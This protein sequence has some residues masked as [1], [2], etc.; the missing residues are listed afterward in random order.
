MNFSAAKTAICLRLVCLFLESLCSG[1]RRHIIGG[2]GQFL[3]G[4]R[5]VSRGECPRVALREPGLAEVRAEEIRELQLRATPCATP[6]AGRPPPPAQMLVSAECDSQREPTPPACV[7]DLR[8]VLVWFALLRRRRRWL[9]GWLVGSGGMPAP[10]AAAADTWQA[11]KR[12]SAMSSSWCWLQERSTRKCLSKRASFLRE[13][14]QAE[15]VR[16]ETRHD[17]RQPAKRRAP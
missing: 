8:F 10:D 2:R 3:E 6:C 14:S 9:G 4:T 13:S 1:T 16:R 5:A 7:C 11:L 12:F 15:A 17:T